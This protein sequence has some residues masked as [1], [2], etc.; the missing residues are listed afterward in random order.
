MTLGPA[1]DS[2]GTI[3]THDGL[4]LHTERFA[5]RGGVRAVVV[6]V[7]GFSAHCGAHRHVAAALAA[8]SF[9]V[10]TFDC[11]GHGRS[12]GRAGFVR[13]FDD[14]GDDLDRVLRAAREWQPGRPLAVVAH[15]HGSTITLDY[16]LGGR[17]TVDALVAVAP[18]LRL[19]MPVP[20]YKR[21][22]SPV[23]G[24]LWPSLTMGNEITSSITC[25]DPAMCAAMDA[26]PLVHHVATPRWFN[27]VQAAQRRILQAAANL[28]VPTLMAVAG[29]DRLVDS[30][31]ALEFAHAAGARVE[32]KV[33]QGLFHEMYLEPERERVVSDIVSWLQGRFDGTAKPDPYT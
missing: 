27:E 24:A 4:A 17:G 1:P 33:Y 12:Q 9:A 25:R 28:Q 21:A 30:A 10:L 3:G 5:P 2:E 20:L 6:M 7:H 8:A 11:R 32:L 29:D 23:L 18:Y 19:R 16:L 31:A 22:L 26:D 15:G 13:R 14:Y